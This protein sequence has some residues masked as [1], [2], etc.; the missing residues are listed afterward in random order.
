MSVYVNFNPGYW[1][2]N[3]GYRVDLYTDKVIKEQLLPRHK[4]WT[5]ENIRAG[6]EHYSRQVQN[7]KLS[8][9]VLESYVNPRSYH[10][11]LDDVLDEDLSKVDHQLG[12]LKIQIKCSDEKGYYV[13]GDYCFPNIGE[14]QIGPT[15]E[16]CD[17]VVFASVY[18]W[19]NVPDEAVLEEYGLEWSDLKPYLVPGVD[20]TPW[21]LNVKQLPYVEFREAIWA[22]DL[23]I[24]EQN[25]RWN[26]S[27]QHYYYD[28]RSY[29]SPVSE[30]PCLVEAFQNAER[31]RN[32]LEEK[33]GRRR[34]TFKGWIAKAANAQ[35]SASK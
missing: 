19:K 10:Q 27:A 12:D 23:V 8:E 33:H 18:G 24:Q 7:G 21:S 13:D 16:Q 22:K 15:K 29:T 1:T 6:Q 11:V 25:R 17:L 20:G 26:P 32:G 14:K 34:R 5:I 4:K 2:E 9:F 3:G 28:Q 35:R 31:I 30:F